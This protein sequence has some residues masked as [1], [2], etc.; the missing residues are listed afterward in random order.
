MF[1]VRFNYYSYII[2]ILILLL[3]LLYHIVVKSLFQLT[4]YE[5]NNK[6]IG[7]E[8][9]SV[10]EFIPCQE[11]IKPWGSAMYFYIALS[12]WLPLLFIFVG[13]LLL[14]IRV[15]KSYKIHNELT[16]E[17]VRR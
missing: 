5:S 1:C 11:K 9:D 4:I 14:I 2:I 12:T 6:I 3:L 16:R 10:F 17:C 7:Y 13:N 8:T 15:R